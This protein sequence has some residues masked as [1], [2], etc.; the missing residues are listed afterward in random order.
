MSVTVGRIVYSERCRQITTSLECVCV[1]R[2]SVDVIIF[3]SLSFFEKFKY[4]EKVKKKTIFLTENKK[5]QLLIFFLFFNFS[6]GCDC[7]KCEFF[8]SGHSRPNQ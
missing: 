2:V 1:A 5:N 3:L 4:I 7:S 8:G 6:G